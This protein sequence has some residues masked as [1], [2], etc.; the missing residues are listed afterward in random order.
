[1]SAISVRSLQHPSIQPPPPTPTYKNTPTP[2]DTCAHAFE[3][4]TRGLCRPSPAGS[5]LHTRRTISF[6]LLLDEERSFILN[7]TDR[8]LKTQ[9]K[10]KKWVFK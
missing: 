1:M 2:L 3:Q 7:T 9:I 10:S 4:V 5:N 8:I 6:S